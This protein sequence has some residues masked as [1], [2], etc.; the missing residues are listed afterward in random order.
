MSASSEP[1]LNPS[2][3]PT[4]LP[5]L[6]NHAAQQLRKS[7]GQKVTAVVKG[8]IEQRGFGGACAWGKREG[9]KKPCTGCA[10]AC[11]QRVQKSWRNQDLRL[12]A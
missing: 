9:E 12:C 8:D 10:K 4:P 11:E 2:S 1:V 7:S 3:P 6:F 5:L